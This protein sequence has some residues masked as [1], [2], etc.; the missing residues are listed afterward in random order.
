MK[1]V[2]NELQDMTEDDR[3]E[4]QDWINLH[5]KELLEVQAEM[6]KSPF[7]D[8]LEAEFLMYVGR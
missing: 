7:K 8:K 1:V 6:Q 2:R 4:A 3:R 5:S